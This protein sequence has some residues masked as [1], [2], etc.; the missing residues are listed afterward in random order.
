[1]KTRQNLERCRGQLNRL[2]RQRKAKLEQN[3]EFVRGW[4]TGV[5]LTWN[6]NIRQRHLHQR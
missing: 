1:M 4:G 6:L 2:G 3:G 5:K